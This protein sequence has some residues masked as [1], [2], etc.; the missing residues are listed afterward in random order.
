MPDSVNDAEDAAA[1]EAEAYF[2]S[3]DVTTFDD[4]RFSQ[5]TALALADAGFK[6]PTKVQA[7]SIPRLMTGVDVVGAAKTGSGK[8]LSFVLP[9]IERLVERKF[10]P[11]AGVGVLIVSPTRE[12]ALQIYGV[13]A[14]MLKNHVGLSHSLVIG[15]A[16]RRV[17]AERL[18][19][20]SANNVLV[21]TP[22]RLVRSAGL[23]PRSMCR[24]SLCCE[25]DDGC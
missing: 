7:L 14:Q 22:G 3:G 23:I 17:E 8:T 6:R 18:A 25:Y 15:G 20:K 1:P 9:A 12:L 19:D 10:K 21:A 24:S 16:N 2:A 13:V 11:S 4:F 5:P